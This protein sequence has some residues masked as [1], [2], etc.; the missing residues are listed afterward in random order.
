MH[1]SFIL[2]AWEKPR[3]H[4]PDR[5]IEKKKKT[6]LTLSDCLHEGWPNDPKES[7]RERERHA[8]I[9]RVQWFPFGPPCSCYSGHITSIHP[10]ESICIVLWGEAMLLLAS[11]IIIDDNG[12]FVEGNGPHLDTHTFTYECVSI[13]NRYCIL[14]KEGLAWSLPLLDDHLSNSHTWLR[15]L[16][17]RRGKKWRVNEDKWWYCISQ[18]RRLEY[19]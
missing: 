18:G 5:S 19:I 12:W 14:Q 15:S 1:K 6:S 3:F 16:A 7:V 8:I 17:L 4:H 2:R 9:K 13:L 10:L 11:I